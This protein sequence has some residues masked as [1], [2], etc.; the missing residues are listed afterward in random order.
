MAL[1]DPDHGGDQVQRTALLHK[2]L[3]ISPN[4]AV[5]ARLIEES[6]EGFYIVVPKETTA[7]YFPRSAVALVYFLD[8]AT[9][10][11]LL[12]DAK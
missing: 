6:D 4:K 5:P 7:I 1:G 3:P 8:K 2:R 11:P 12:R 9:D 10:L